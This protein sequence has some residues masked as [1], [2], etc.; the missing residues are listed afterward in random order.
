MSA[1]IT[2]LL[3]I[4]EFAKLPE[5]GQPTELV[6]GRVITMNPPKP[7]HGRVCVK[8]T[9]RLDRF[10]E[11]HDLGRVFSNDT[12]VITERDPDTLRGADI[13]F[14]SYKK[15]PKGPLPEG[16]IEIPPD[17][18]IEVLS[19]DD[20]WSSVLAK[21]GE[22]LE[23]GVTVVVVLDPAEEKAHVYRGDRPGQVLSAQDELA[24]DDVLPGFRARVETFF[25]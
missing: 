14:W 25:E 5:N 9:T 2:S 11:E 18:I 22:Y 4:E 17:L 6:R 7:R 20:R 21:V 15:L 1:T 23:A 24:L 16:Y 19:P 3:T 12:G 8:T 13:S 10:A